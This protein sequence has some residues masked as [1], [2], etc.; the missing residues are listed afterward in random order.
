MPSPE[1]GGGGLTRRRLLKTSAA[2]GLTGALAGAVPASATR[3]RSAPAGPTVAVFGAGVAGLSAA[4]ELAERGFRVTVFERKAL[5]GKARSIPVPGTGRGG[6]RDLPAEHGFR[7][8]FS[9]YRNLPDIMKRIPFGRNPNGVYDNLRGVGHARLARA[10]A[11]DATI[12]IAIEGFIRY[13]AVKLWETIYSALRT[14]RGIPIDQLLFFARQV[15]MYFSSGDL[16]RFGQWEYV[17]WW[18]FTRA[19][20]SSREYRLQFADG[21]TRNLAAAR[22]ADMSVN[23][24]GIVG[25]SF[26]YSLLYR[27]AGPSDRA[28]NAP[29]NESWIDPWIAYLRSLGVTFEVGQQLTRLTMGGGRI[30]EATVQGPDGA[31]RPVVAD[32]YVSAVP[33]ERAMA[34]F[35]EPILT[36]S[37]ELR[38]LVKL[39]T[40]W[41][42]GVIFHLDREVPICDGHISYVDSQN[43][44]TSISQAQIW[45][46]TRNISRDYGDGRAKE[47]FS[48]I[49]SDWKAPG[50]I[51]EKPLWSLPHEQVIEEVWEQMKAHLNDWGDRTYLTD[52]MVVST[53]LDP[54]IT[55]PAERAGMDRIAEND[56][57]LL[58][59]TPGSWDDRPEARTGIPNLVLAGDYVRNTMNCATMES[60]CETGRRAA[61]VVCEDAGVTGVPV[62]NRWLPPENGGLRRMDDKRYQRGQKH[63]LD[64]PWGWRTSMRLRSGELSLRGLADEHDLTSR[65]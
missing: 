33:V 32:H 27:P 9:F 55:Y 15:A 8:E 13:D 31:S 54:A 51:Y 35:D 24:T 37:P 1:H 42:N 28:L 16:R 7:A 65:W 10:G 64:F 6:R 25:E 45:R 22:P 56:E 21:L 59:N 41:M 2:A 61:N 26:A 30:T 3:T 60:A 50:M 39:R 14:V 48:A 12:P 11:S 46:K 47:S 58:I 40:D 19:A 44:L 20:R 34:V 43:A 63:I 17:N 52:D 4:H 49:I 38:N 18:D 62:L 29:T 36:A 57:P 5:G 23:S 53:W